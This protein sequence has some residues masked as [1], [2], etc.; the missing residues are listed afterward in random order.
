MLGPY[1]GPSRLRAR[2]PAGLEARRPARPREAQGSLPSSWVPGVAARPRTSASRLPRPRGAPRLEG[3]A[4]GV[5]R[6]AR[7]G[8]LL[9]RWVLTILKLSAKSWRPFATRLPKTRGGGVRRE[10]G[11]GFFYHR[12]QGLEVGS[13]SPD[14]G[15][16]PVVRAGPGRGEKWGVG[17]VGS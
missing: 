16:L 7:E 5:R 10:R 6:R 9:P 14:A 15:G 4:V 8:S 12:L 11:L 3:A 2:L 1:R 17:W 13:E